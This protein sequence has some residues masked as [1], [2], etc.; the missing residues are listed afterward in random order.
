MMIS[1][2][3][4]AFTWANRTI[5]GTILLVM[6]VLVFANVVLR[7]VAGISLTWVEELTRYMMI[8]LAWLAIGLAVRQGAHIAVDTLV[9]SLPPLWSRLL[10]V[11]ILALVIGFFVAVAWYG[12]EY[13]LF[14][15]GQESAVLRLSLGA[16][17]LAIPFGSVVMLVHILLAAPDMLAEKPQTQEF[18]IL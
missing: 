6:A 16:V 18:G 4:H 9:Q 5:V 10:R 12:F 14:T 7:Y 3:D 1:R 8:W 17:Y 15:W 2:F 11:V 13:A